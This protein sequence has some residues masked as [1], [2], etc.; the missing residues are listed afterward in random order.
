MVGKKGGYPEEYQVWKLAY[1]SILT[2]FVESFLLS[3]QVVFS[4]GF[5]LFSKCIFLL[6]TTN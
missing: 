3:K 2:I 6:K 4:N 1:F 5:L